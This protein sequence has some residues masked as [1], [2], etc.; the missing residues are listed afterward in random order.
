[1][2]RLV[3]TLILIQFATALNAQSP[4]AAAD[5]GC[6]VKRTPLFALKTNLLFDAVSTPNLEI[7]AAFPANRIS[8]MS[9]YWLPWYIWDKNSKAYQLKYC[10]SEIRLW[11]GNRTRKD[12]LHGHFL[13]I[14]GGGGRFDLEWESE[15]HQSEL[16]YSVG[17][18]Y[19]YSFKL[20][21]SFRIETSLSA[22]YLNAGYKYYIGMVNDKYLVWQR[23]GIFS[24]F[25][26]LKAKVS[27]SWIMHAKKGGRCRK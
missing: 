26:P 19:G 5:L 14:Y 15:G 27:L 3:L 20:N 17:L 13:G 24:Y 18:T 25:G 21:R 6:A 7:E 1:M 2:K 8:L 11:L 9:E 16:Y 10:G 4:N 22:G 12:I 23:D